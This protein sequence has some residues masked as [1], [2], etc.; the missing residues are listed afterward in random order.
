M[1]FVVSYPKS[2]NT[3]IRLVATAYGTDVEPEALMRSTEPTLGEM[4]LKD[5]ETRHYQ[6][7]SPVPLQDVD[8]GTEVRLRPAAMLLLEQTASRLTDRA[9]FLIQS[10][11]IHASVNDIPLWHPDWTDRIIN[12]VRDPREVCCSQAAH[13]GNSY[14]ETAR[15]MSE[16]RARTGP[17]ESPDVRWLIGSWSAH[18]RGWLSADGFSVHTVRYEDLNADPLG[19]FYDILDFL[20]VSNLSMDA[21]R[22]AIETTQ[23]DRL[24]E[25]EAEHGFPEAGDKQFFRS[26]ETDGWKEELPVE[27]ARTIERDHGEVMEA[28]GYL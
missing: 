24:Q 1:D 26:G 3:W 13:F 8:F 2:G 10:H 21:V 15:I 11:H 7:V 25:A 5:V 22:D 14:E 19:E 4:N 23:F 20:G 12:P 6:A 18:I 9:P 28:L 27:V 17:G 16:S